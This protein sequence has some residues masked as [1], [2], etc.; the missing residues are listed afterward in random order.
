MKVHLRRSNAVTAEKRLQ[1]CLVTTPYK[2]EGRGGYILK[3]NLIQVLESILDDEIY[4]SEIKIIVPDCRIQASWMPLRMAEILIVQSKYVYHLLKLRKSDHI[5]FFTMGAT[6][7][8]PLLTAK[9][10]KK[11]TVYFI[12]GLTGSLAF[13]K[14]MKIVYKQTCFGI[15]GRILPHIF[16]GLERLNYNLADMLLVESPNLAHQIASDKYRNKP[17]LNGALFVDTNAFSPRIKLSQRTDTVSYFGFISEHKGIINFIEAIPL[18]LNERNDVQFVIGGAGPALAEIKERLKNSQVI[19][20]VVLCGMIHH[21]EIADYL[22]EAKLVV[23][24][25]YGEGLPN[26]V[27]EAMACGTPVLATPVGGI[28]DVIRDGDT[29]FL[30]ENNSPECIAS[31]VIRALEHPDLEGNAR[32]ARALVEREFTFDKAVERYGKILKDISNHK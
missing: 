3:S 12:S 9:I 4:S 11:K 21:K 29:G 7:F 26:I 13:N 17:I 8:L 5:I 14:V 16:S 27:L 6:Y 19:D 1:I 24:P 28:P 15:G 2:K 32:R 25:S 10:L 23:L 30:M 22:N 20:E 18:I 31:N